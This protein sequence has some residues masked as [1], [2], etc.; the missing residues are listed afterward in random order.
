MGELRQA[1]KEELQALDLRQRLG[2][3]LPVARSWT[4]LARLSLAQRRYDEAAELA[5]RAQSAFKMQREATA[6]DRLSVLFILGLADCNS[7]AYVSAIP[8]LQEA[9]SLADANFRRGDFPVGLAHFLLGFA[10]W[11]SGNMPAAAENMGQGTAIMR[12][13]LGWGHPMYVTALQQYSRFL[14]TTRQMAAAREVDQRILQARSVVDVRALHASG[15][16]D[17]SSLR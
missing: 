1:R 5:R 13:Q 3:A 2:D 7:R 10:N 6:I 17:L 9:V 4:D 14:Q 8:P 11:K 12:N 15:A 16:F